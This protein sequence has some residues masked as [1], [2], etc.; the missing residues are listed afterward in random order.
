MKTKPIPARNLPRPKIH[1][2][3]ILKKY[4]LEERKLSLELSPS[5]RE[6]L[7]DEGYNPSYGARPLKRTIQ[8]ELENPLSMAI[9]QG[10]FVDGDKII[11]EHTPDGMLFRK[12]ES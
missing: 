9:L 11:A 10:R 6:F 8:R 1:P 5:A 3:V 7:V 2:G 4:V 12:A